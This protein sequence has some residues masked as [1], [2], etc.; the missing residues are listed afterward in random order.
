MAVKVAADPFVKIKTLIQELI[1]RLL[2]EEADEASHK[3]WC[4]RV[5]AKP[6]GS[7]REQTKHKS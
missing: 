7:N 5:L 2:Q 4:A 6:S 3:G 1:E